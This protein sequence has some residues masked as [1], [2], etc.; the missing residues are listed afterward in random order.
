MYAEA[1]GAGG[2][3]NALLPQFNEETALAIDGINDYFG[4]VMSRVIAL[5]TRQ[6]SL[7]E[8]RAWAIHNGDS[9]DSLSKKQRQPVP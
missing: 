7:T 6:R 4:E 8:E 9:L 3:L 5:E 2:Q 1:H